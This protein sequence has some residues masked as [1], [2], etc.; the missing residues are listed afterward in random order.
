MNTYIVGWGHTP[1][2]RWEGEEVES[3]LTRVIDQAQPS[4]NRPAP[5]DRQSQRE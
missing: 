4:W 1:F 5:D 2:Q 3:L